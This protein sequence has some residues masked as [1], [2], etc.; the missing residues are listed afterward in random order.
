MLPKVEE[1]VEDLLE[2][3]DTEEEPSR[4]YKLHMGQKRILG[5]TDE[6]D[7]M[8]QAVYKILNTERYESLIYSDNYGVEL[9]ELIGQPMEYVLAELET[10]IS[11]ALLADDRIEEVTDFYF[12]GKSGKV[13]VSFTVK[14]SLG[15][16]EEN[17]EVEV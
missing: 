2:D 12:S 17:M 4:T 3:I 1:V 16:L 10:R 7:A 6:L 13:T 8:H 9:Q 11:E 5:M 15:E 14:T